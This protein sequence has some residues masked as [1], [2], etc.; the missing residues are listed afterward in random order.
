MFAAFQRAAS[1]AKVNCYSFEERFLSWAETLR[2][3]PP[4]AYKWQRVETND[5]FKQ[6]N[7]EYALTNDDFKRNKQRIKMQLRSGTI[8][9]LISAQM[10]VVQIIEN[11]VVR[12][13]IGQAKKPAS[14][15][16]CQKPFLWVPRQAPPF[17]GQWKIERFFFGT[18]TSEAWIC[19]CPIR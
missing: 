8:K 17:A 4:Q 3:K 18:F 7:K 6:K 1:V 2:D 9:V 19:R 13:Q 12:C 5:D 10:L 14:S 15:R 11:N 16:V